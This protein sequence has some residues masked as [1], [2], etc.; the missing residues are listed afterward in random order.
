MQ[1]PIAEAPP[2]EPV[3]VTMR[4]MLTSTPEAAEAPVEREPVLRLESVSCWYGTFRAVKDVSMYIKAREV[5]A[6]IGPSGCG[7]TTLLRT[8]NRMNDLIPGYRTDGHINFEGA[9]LYGPGVDPVAVRRRIGM[10]FQKPNP[11][12]KSVYDNVAFGPRINGFKGNM[13]DLVEQSLRRAAL[14]DDVKDKLKQSGMALSGGQQQ[15]LCIARTIAVEP[16][17]IL[18]DEPCS[19]LDPRS[20]LQIEELM[21]EL[22]RD[23]TIVIVTHNMQQA[24]RAS[25]KTV[26]LT[27]GDDRAGYVVEVDETVKIFTNPRE[28]LTE[29]YISGR[30][31]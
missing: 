21:A 18:M 15:R 30:F 14:W 27:M 16:E 25:D 8:M 28:Q 26:F 10:V 31:G 23:Y 13:D 17:V 29:D 4:P 22:K 20:T 11:F 5:T 1:A 2:R 3:G 24:A 7:K 12:P 19:A 9:D 6:L